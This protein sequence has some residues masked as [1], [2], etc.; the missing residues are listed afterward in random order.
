MPLL[1]G[2]GSVL[3]RNS[4]EPYATLLA[5]ARS[6]YALRVNAAGNFLHSSGYL[7]CAHPA[8]LFQRPDASSAALI[9]AGNLSGIALSLTQAGSQ[10]HPLSVS[11]RTGHLY[12][13]LTPQ[14]RQVGLLVQTSNMALRQGSYT[15]AWRVLAPRLN[16]PR[17]QPQ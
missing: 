15:R 14:Q 5:A 16:S 1:I 7:T 8:Q 13:K 11:A 10:P 3:K 9:T 6:E 17:A 12:T 4:G 2:R